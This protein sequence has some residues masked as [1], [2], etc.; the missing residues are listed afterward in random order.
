MQFDNSNEKNLFFKISMSSSHQEKS[1]IA[2]AFVLT[3]SE[4]TLA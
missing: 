2:E 4:Y 3:V 1:A